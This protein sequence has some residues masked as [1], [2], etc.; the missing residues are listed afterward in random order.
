MKPQPC[1]CTTLSSC[2]KKSITS[3]HNGRKSR[4]FVVNIGN[5]TGRIIE[6]PKLEETERISNPAPGST[7]DTQKSDHLSG[8]RNISSWN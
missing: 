2:G 4:F 3:R 5:L 6:Y 8:K 7:Q 1:C